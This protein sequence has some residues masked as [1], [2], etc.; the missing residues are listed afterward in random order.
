LS[1]LDQELE[2]NQIGSVANK[3][4]ESSNKT[5][6]HSS[7]ELPAKQV[8]AEISHASPESLSVVRQ[9]SKTSTHGLK[10]EVTNKLENLNLKSPKPQ[11]G[12]DWMGLVAEALGGDDQDEE[13]SF[14]KLPVGSEKEQVKIMSDQD[15]ITDLDESPQ[16]QQQHKAGS[17]VFMRYDKYD[18][19]EP[20]SA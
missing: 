13:V 4:Y 19:H 8:V 18:P 17:G 9:M 12:L 5:S 2:I 10:V 16:R 11:K 14:L 15:R 6:H 7:E 20:H 1:D 3:P